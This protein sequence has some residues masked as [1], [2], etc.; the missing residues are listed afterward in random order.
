MEGASSSIGE[1]A[2][3][4]VA[5]PANSSETAT[6][7][8][9]PGRTASVRVLDILGQRMQQID[10]VTIRAEGTDLPIDVSKWPNGNYI[11][12]AIGDEGSHAR[13]MLSVQH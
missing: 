13:T 8:G 6:I 1:L 10:D 3:S 7:S 4:L 2:V 5:N 11:I 9:L 12:E